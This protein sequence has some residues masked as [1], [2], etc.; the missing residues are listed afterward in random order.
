MTYI[1][2]A[3]II[4]RFVSVVFYYPLNQKHVLRKWSLF[5]RSFKHEITRSDKHWLKIYKKVNS[6]DNVGCL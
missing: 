2:K 1:Q 5:L 6:E 3:R 4:V